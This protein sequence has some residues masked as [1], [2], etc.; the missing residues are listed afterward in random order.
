MGGGCGVGVGIL[1]VKNMWKTRPIPQKVP[2]G[3]LGVV[4]GICS[5]F[6]SRHL[7]L[8]AAI[9]QKRTFLHMGQLQGYLLCGISLSVPGQV[10]VL[11]PAEVLLITGRKYFSS[12][13]K[14]PQM[15]TWHAKH[16]LLVFCGISPLIKGQVK[17]DA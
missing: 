8:H 11:E 1:E 12:L 7:C 4:T 13:L 9:R 14:Q 10:E 3:Y 17:Q 2:A 16:H 6:S 15:N 5:G